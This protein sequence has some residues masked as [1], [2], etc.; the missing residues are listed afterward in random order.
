MTAPQRIFQ[1]EWLHKFQYRF[2]WL[3]GYAVAPLA[4]IIAREQGALPVLLWMAKRLLPVSTFD[5]SEVESYRNGATAAFVFHF[6]RRLAEVMFLQDYTGTWNRESRLEFL[7]YLVWGLCAG[8]VLSKAPLTSFGAPPKQFRML[9]LSLFIVGELGNFWCHYHLRE[10][11]AS[12]KKLG[13]TGSYIIP[14][15]G[16]FK[17]VSCPHYTFELLSWLGYMIHAG[18]DSASAFLLIQSVAAMAPFARD[19]HERYLEIWRKKGDSEQGAVD[20]NTKWRML[21]LLW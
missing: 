3:G 21:P 11:R 2:P 18:C 12:R 20:P 4:F 1:T 5:A 13:V 7:Y 6:L 19:R 10:I 8:S 9:G 17:L 14:A 15:A 16:P